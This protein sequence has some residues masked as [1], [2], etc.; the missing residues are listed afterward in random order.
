M[1]YGTIIEK[2]IIQNQAADVI[3]SLLVLVQFSGEH[4]NSWTTINTHQ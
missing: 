3:K 4:C 1:G 2:K